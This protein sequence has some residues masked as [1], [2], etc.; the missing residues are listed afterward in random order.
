MFV[1]AAAWLLT[2]IVLVSPVSGQNTR[3]A[4]LERQRAEKAKELKPYEPTKLETWVTRAEEG[5]LRRM[6]APHN[7]FFA[8]YGYTHR[9]VGAGIG[10]GGGWRHD[11]F[12]RQAR[13][14]LEGGATLRS[15][16]MV[17]A[18]FSLPRLADERVE[19]G[20]EG[21]YRYQPQD[22]FYGLGP[23]TLEEMRVNYLYEGS[24]VQGR[25]ILKPRTWLQLGTRAGS[26]TNSVDSG[27][28]DRFPSIEGS[29]DD[30]AA[31]GLL[32]QP[33]YFYGEGFAEVDYRD[34]PGN[35]RS[36]G[37]YVVSWRAYNDSDLDRYSFHEFNA[38]ARQFFP[39]FDK[40]RVFALQTQLLSTTPRSGHEVPF[41][42]QPTLG[43][44]HALRGLKDYRFRD[45]S[46]FYVNVEY[47]WEAFAA[48]DMALFT[49]LG[50]VAPRVSDLDFGALKRS[51]GIG[52]R[53][54][55]P[56]SVFYRVD[57]ATGAG[58]GWHIHLKFSNAF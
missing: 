52:L 53:F 25:A 18:D 47:R 32:V 45:R 21:V 19:L 4:L 42:M 38:H 22:D 15:Y 51:Y 33:D 49:D 6:I 39:I 56:G 55:T 2:S 26:L 34:Q 44:S 7:G 50:T 10:F 57:V 20:V 17:R 43:G 9:P 27:K 29:F 1:R 13:V 58:E 40:K 24:E 36:G 41:F 8:E 11:L 28:D 35:A 30:S 12:D 5:R 23:D 46:I 48:L 14:V 31:P 37:Y 54:N 16:Y 3:S